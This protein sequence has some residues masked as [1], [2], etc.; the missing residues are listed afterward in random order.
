MDDPRD[1]NTDEPD[2]TCPAPT[3]E[4]TTAPTVTDVVPTDGEQ[5]VAT[6]TNVETAFSEAMNPDTINTSTFILTKQ[7]SS[8]PVEATVVYETYN[9]TYSVARLSPNS[10]LASNT[11]YTATIKG[12][13]SGAK[14]LAGNALEQD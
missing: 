6:G 13:A 1:G 2:E 7:D 10:E 8:I 14:D 11:T 12:G 9:P 4:D 3:E 5:N